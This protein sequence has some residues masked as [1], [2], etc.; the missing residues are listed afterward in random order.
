MAEKRTVKT[1]SKVKKKHW[2]PIL[3]PKSF[4]HAVIGE[5]FIAENEELLKKSITTNLMVI[6]DDPRKQGYS[7]RFDVKE[8]KEGRAHT[9]VVG[10]EMT[11]SAIKR[12]IRRGRDKVDDSFVVRIGGGRL[13]RVKPTL[14]TNTK[15]S[16][17]AQTEIRMTVRKRLRDMYA[18]MRFDDIVKDIIE[19]KTQRML[20]DLCSKTH[21][22]RSADI[23]FITIVPKDRK[24]TAEMEEIMEKEVAEEDARRA[25]LA[26]A[27]AAAGVGEEIALQAAP[28][29]G[30]RKPRKKELAPQ[31]VEEA[32]AGAGKSQPT[33]GPEEPG[34]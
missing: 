16:K 12:L 22:L 17:S 7:V 32:E 24:M 10:I 3:A 23:R 1:S 8:V 25:Q 21:P 9:Q 4:D 30:S 11:P 18:K 15:A 6:T 20:R 31:E 28:T 33:E 13:V 5:C 34:V 14:V 26:S 27:A 19:M 2:A 29:R